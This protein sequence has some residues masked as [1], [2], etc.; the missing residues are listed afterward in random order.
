MTNHLYGFLCLFTKYG[1]H[2]KSL[3]ILI[4]NVDFRILT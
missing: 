1:L 3:G 4:K 2:E